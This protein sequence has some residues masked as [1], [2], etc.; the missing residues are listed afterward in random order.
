VA[1]A[2]ADARSGKRLWSQFGSRQFVAVAS[3]PSILA[4]ALPA[5]SR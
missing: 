2:A 3:G 5:D 1:F 4:F